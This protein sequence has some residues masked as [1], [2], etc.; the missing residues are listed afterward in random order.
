MRLVSAF[1]LASSCSNKVWLFCGHAPKDLSDREQAD[2]KQV[3]GEK[4]AE[5]AKRDWKLR[6]DSCSNKDVFV[7]PPSLSGTETRQHAI[8]VAGVRAQSS[9]E[10]VFDH[11]SLPT[12]LPALQTKWRLAGLQAVSFLTKFSSVGVG[13]EKR[14]LNL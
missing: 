9:Y 13:R 1:G 4:E 14:Y 6:S 5:Q 11:A 10:P 2:L 7:V 8:G 3:L 12:T